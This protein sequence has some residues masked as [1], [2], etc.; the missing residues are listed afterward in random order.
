MLY[1][2][3]IGALFLGMLIL[4][5]GA[6]IVGYH[7]KLADNLGSGV[8]SYDRFRFWGLVTCGV[9]VAIMLSLHSIPLNWLSRSLFGGI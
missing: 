1:E 5:V 6:L 4:A 9:G 2:F 7:Q 8:S 3:S